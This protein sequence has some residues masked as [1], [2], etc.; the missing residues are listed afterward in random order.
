MDKKNIVYL[1]V[2][3]VVVG[4][5]ILLS[6][7]SKKQALLEGTSSTVSGTAV[8][9][10]TS[11]EPSFEFGTISMEKGNV[12]HVF[13]VKN[14]G[15]TPVTVT[16]IFTSCMCTLATFSLNSIKDGP[17][18]MP[19]HTPG[20]SIAIVVAPGETAEVEAVFDPAAHGPAGTGMAR[21]VVYLETDSVSKKVVELSFEANVTP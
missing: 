3:L 5:L 8:G 16:K 2:I 12:S 19:G 17:F 1:V 11:D 4:G 15:Q 18:G 9:V 21:R 10:L 20:R 6:N 14:T 7:S 13:T